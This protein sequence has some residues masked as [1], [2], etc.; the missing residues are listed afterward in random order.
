MPS[1]TWMMSE[2]LREDSL[3]PFMVSTT[4][5]TTEPPS[6][7]MV[8]ALL[9]SW[10]AWWALSAFCLTV[11]LSCPMDDAVFSSALA[12]LSVRADR[13]LLPEAIS[14]LAVATLSALTLTLRTMPPKLACIRAMAVSSCTVSSLPDGCTAEDRSPCAIWSAICTAWAMGWDSALASHR[15]ANISAAVAITMPMA[16]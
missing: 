15:A 1:I 16:T 7:A 6:T 8:E 2:I 12:W 13:S 10:L 14:A 11:A 4:C 3:M 5:P 9:A